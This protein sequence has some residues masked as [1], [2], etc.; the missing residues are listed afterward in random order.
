MSETVPVD[1]MEAARLLGDDIS[2]YMK[3]QTA[4]LSDTFEL[5]FKLNQAA[6]GRYA[7]LTQEAA[8]LKDRAKRLQEQEIGVASF[9]G[10]LAVIEGDLSN[11]EATIQ[12]LE[13]YCQ[14][15]EQKVATSQ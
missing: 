10:N 8:T 11:L 15:L 6:I 7:E 4:E 12:K 5:V 14:L 2:K 13:S 3:L 9:L 1:L